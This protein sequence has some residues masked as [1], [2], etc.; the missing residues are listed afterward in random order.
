MGGG[1][2]AVAVVVL[3][4]G[5]IWQVTGDRCESWQLTGDRCYSWQVIDV[6]VDRW[7]MWQLTGDRWQMWQLTGDRQHVTRDMWY[8]TPGCR[9]RTLQ[10]FTYPVYPVYPATTLEGFN[11]N[12]NVQNQIKSEMLFLP[13]NFLYFFFVVICLLK[14]IHLNVATGDTR[15][16]IC[17]T[18]YKVR[19]LQHFT[20]P[21]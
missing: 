7:Q 19:T 17:N 3:V 5:D 2:V 21:V 11:A 15:Y 10:H 1:S 6:T 9:V 4:R 14:R 12:I 8:V 13:K 16:V 18:G 20:S